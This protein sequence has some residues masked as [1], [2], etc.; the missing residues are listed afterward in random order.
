MFEG[1]CDLLRIKPIVKECIKVAD[2]YIPELVDT[3]ASQ[4]NPQVVCHVAGLC[5]NERI[6]KMIEDSKNQQDNTPKK[7]DTCEGCHTVVDVM[8]NKLNK[9]SRDDILQ[10]FLTV[11]ISILRM[12]SFNALFLGLW[13]IGQLF[14]CL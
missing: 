14:R 12:H 2:D 1:S 6:H 5:N 3:L 13:K 11:I 10:G 9:A 8:Q 7:P 4:M